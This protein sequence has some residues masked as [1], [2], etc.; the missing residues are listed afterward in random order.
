MTSYPCP[1]CKKLLSLFS[2]SRYQRSIEGDGLCRD[3]EFP[4]QDEN[5]II[6]KSAQ[7][8]SQDKVEPVIVKAPP[9]PPR[10]WGANETL[11]TREK[12]RIYREKAQNL[13]KE[14]KRRCL[15]SYGEL[16]HRM[17]TSN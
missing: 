11:T 10:P 9:L 6:A 2:F 16:R 13:E 12:I 8:S 17:A 4:S 5:L 1:R 7:I 3:C 14:K 15:R